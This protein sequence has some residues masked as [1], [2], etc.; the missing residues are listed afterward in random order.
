[1]VLLLSFNLI[2]REV[3]EAPSA[4]W[5]GGAGKLF[6]PAG[7]L[8]FSRGPAAWAPCLSEGK[9]PNNGPPFPS[10]V[11]GLSLTACSHRNSRA[12]GVIIST[13]GRRKP[14]LREAVRVWRGRSGNGEQ[15]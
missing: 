3:S 4:G 14:R 15:S 5:K 9:C 8:E 11:P 7:S 10:W 13:S 2:F 6:L 1:M 12:L